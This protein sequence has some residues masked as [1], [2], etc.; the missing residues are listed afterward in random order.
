MK[1]VLCKI[2][3]HESCYCS[4]VGGAASYCDNNLTEHVY[5]VHTMGKACSN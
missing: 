2:Q 4:V 3:T 1:N 5:Q